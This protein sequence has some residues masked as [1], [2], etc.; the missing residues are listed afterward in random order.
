ML[1]TTVTSPSTEIIDPTFTTG[2]NTKLFISLC[3]KM[4]SQTETDFRDTIN[5][6]IGTVKALKNANTVVR[7][8]NNATEADKDAVAYAMVLKQFRDVEKT[9]LRVTDKYINAMKEFGASARTM[10]K[11]GNGLLADQEEHGASI[12]TGRSGLKYAFTCKAI[13][14]QW[15]ALKGAFVEMRR[16]SKAVQKVKEIQEEKTVVFVDSENGNKLKTGL[17]FANLSK[18]I[19]ELAEMEEEEK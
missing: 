4:E 3:Q 18:E 19:A 16:L 7:S 14:G 9:K 2:Q 8:M 12:K 13:D 10:I 5:D 15:K 11:L 1:I 17:T 6:Q